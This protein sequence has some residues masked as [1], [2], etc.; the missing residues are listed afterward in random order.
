MPSHVRRGRY[1]DWNAQK[2]AARRSSAP[3]ASPRKS[4]IR[5]CRAPAEW[6]NANALIARSSRRCAMAPVSHKHRGMSTQSQSERFVVIAALD[7]ILADRV[8]LVAARLAIAGGEL[9]FVHV[10][11]LPP[12]AGSS[13]ASAV[14]GWRARLQEAGAS[15]G[16]THKGRIV[17]HLAAGD[18]CDEILLLAARIEADLLLVGTHGRKGVD[19]LLLGS[20]AERLVRRASC[21]VLVVR[22]KN[23]HAGLPPEIEPPCA[24]C[25]EARV[26]SQGEKMWCVRHSQRHPHGRAHYEL[27]EPFAL[28]SSIIRP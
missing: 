1:R 8:A 16:E 15:A 12:L 27:P 20:V 14:E 22:E 28:G 6:E 13:T 10:M 9:H 26:A 21:P 5:R 18:P 7:G 2:L 17:G 19:R 11:T 3:L 4:C 23:Y 25:L 24:D